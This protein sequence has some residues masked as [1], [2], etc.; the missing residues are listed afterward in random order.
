MWLERDSDAQE[1]REEERLRQKA[2]AEDRVPP[3]HQPCSV[4]ER[5]GEEQEGGG[6]LEDAG[7]QLLA[8][9]FEDFVQGHSS[10][11]VGTRTNI[12]SRPEMFPRKLENT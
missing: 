4:G 7:T 2:E 12:S 10:V 6:G 5:A 9:H 1:A 3:R 11:E 8:E